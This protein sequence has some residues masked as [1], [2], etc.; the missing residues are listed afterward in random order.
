MTTNLSAEQIEKIQAIFADRAR[1]DRIER[2]VYSH[3][4]GVVPDQIRALIDHTP[5]GIVQPKTV[6]EI[7]R[8][9]K[10]CH[11][12]NIPMVPRGAGSGAYGGAV[13]AKAGIVVDF[14][15]MNKIRSIDRQNKVAVVE[16]GVIW[17]NLENALSENGLALRAYP[18]SAKSSTV[19]GW[20]A[21]GGSGYGSFEYGEC[22]Q[23]IVSVTMVLPN[24][25]LETLTGDDLEKAYRLCG[26][27]G[28]IV[29]ITV[30]VREKEEECVAL[31]AFPKLEQAAKFI[32]AISSTHIPLWSLSLATPAYTS[33]R[34]K[35]SGKTLLPEDSYIVTTVFPRSRRAVIEKQITGLVQSYLGKVM[36][37]EV[38]GEEWADKLYPM[39]FKKLGP[40]LVASEAVIP[41][42]ELAEFVGEIEK[43]F[44]G[45]FALQGTMVGTDKISV[46]GFML[47]DERK[48][49][50]PMAYAC[51]LQ[52]IDSGEKFGGRVYSLGLYFPD[53]IQTLF[54]EKR[55]SD[56]W[57]YKQSVDPRGIM[58]PGKVVPPSMD[59][60]SPTSKLLTAMRVGEAGSGLIGLA[61][62]LL[63]KAQSGDFKSPLD[64]HLT[65][66][67]FSCAQCGYCRNVCTVYDP[68]PWESNSPRGKYYLLNQYIRGKIPMDEELGRALFPCT[69]CKK[70]EFVCQIQAKNADHWVALRQVFIDNGLHNTGLE[71][72]RNNV[73]STGNF[74]GAAPD[75]RMQWLDVPTETK[76]K[77]AVWSGC[78]AQTIQD[79]VSQNVTRILNRLETPFVH[80]KEREQ[81]CGF[82]MGLGGYHEDYKNIVKRNL[83][84]FKEAGVETIV[85][86]CPACIAAFRDDYPKLA[87]EMGID[88]NV[89]F[90]HSAEYLNDLVA[91]GKLKFTE[92]VN[93]TATLHDA[94][95]I[96]R[97]F[98]IYDEPR[99]VLKAIPGLEFKEMKSIRENSLC[100]GLVSA[101][102]SLPSVVANGDKRVQEAV[103]I[104]ADY[105]V[106]TCGGCGSQLN[107][108]CQRMG[109]AVK[110]IDLTMLVAKS[111]G[112]PT[113]DNS[114]KVGAYMGQAV[115]L[116][117]DSGLKPFAV[118]AEAKK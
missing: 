48:L 113:V 8:L 49:G 106:S 12:E 11:E 31:C 14:T 9:A 44:K 21:Q 66:D 45:E 46:Q 62:R 53:R 107:A 47:S 101:F 34:Q 35:T 18:S 79:S 116:L 6:D 59:K 83:E 100:C 64:E 57:S 117:K 7:V 13:P 5:D 17:I 91:E 99:N 61:G 87:R 51:A 71:F 104:N 67:V 81:C 25:Q 77:L 69:T 78:W 27:T 102:D 82:Y 105:L 74:W 10:L 37:D 50:F 68:I 29:Q 80:F 36:S 97:W 118:P 55:L 38:A 96:G 94:C 32:N 1:F 3:D 86:S 89:N 54:D 16:P 2:I 65:D 98:G 93:A 60:N 110:Q 114:E 41:I 26:I 85:T 28:M 108:T 72:I 111:L 19:G 40:S 95:H 43:K 15:R 109:T 20:V 73:N 56:I 90:R 24:G 23:N 52:V 42:S 76:G 4:M 30:K 58:N 70:C 22:R 88:C 63:S 115:E 92:P 33:L 84:M 39:R 112:L 75:A 103:D